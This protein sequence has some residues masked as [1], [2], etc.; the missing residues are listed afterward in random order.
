[1]EKILVKRLTLK[2][3]RD[4]VKVESESWSPELRASSETIKERL[5]R[6]PP[7][8][9]GIY[10]NGRLVGMSIWQPVD[11]IKQTRYENS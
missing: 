11:E 7:G 2:N 1:V 4:M 6:Y 8:N 10:V 9:L 3:L 5:N